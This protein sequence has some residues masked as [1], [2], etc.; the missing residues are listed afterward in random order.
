MAA[1]LLAVPANAEAATAM[2]VPANLQPRV[3][4][5]CARV[6]N[7]IARTDAQMTRLP[8]GPTTVGSIAWVKARAQMAESR[9]R[10]QV[11]NELNSRADVLTQKLA[12]LPNQ[13][14]ALQKV[15]EACKTLGYA[16]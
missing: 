7:L 11:A 12:L 15:Q 4:T 5:L 14:A 10:K 13:K 6:P 1:L 2:S 16:S 9:D 8:S 3:K